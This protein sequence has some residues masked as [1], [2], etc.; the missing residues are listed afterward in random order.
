MPAP[1]SPVP[2]V[3][4]DA[5]ELRYA[6]GVVGV[7]GVDL[8]VALGE[9]V[10]LVG[11]SGC[12]KSTSLRLV[13]GLE[14]P[15]AGRATV[16]PEA[17]PAA[18]V[19]Q[20]ANLLPWRTIVDNVALPLELAKRPDPDRVRDAIARVGLN[21][22][23]KA[24]PREL[25][26]GMRMRASLA[27]ALVIEPRVMLLDEPFGALDEL[28]RNRLQDDLLALHA[29]MGF[30]VLFVT[31]SVTEAVWLAD[32]VLVFSKRPGRITATID[33]D[34]PRPRTPALRTDVAVARLAGAVSA[35]LRE[36]LE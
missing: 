28:T 25:S 4:L 36:G 21:G 3:R 33:V 26:G 30:T 13:A 34:L 24:Y 32:R 7:A 16:A 17:S 9:I 8:S 31:H 18:F 12:G 2:A 6:N 11:P 35:Q 1:A 10:A 23:E 19:F 27:R 14:A 20:D 5:V 15:T 22:F 29:A